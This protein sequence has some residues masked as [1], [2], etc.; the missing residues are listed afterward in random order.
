MTVIKI[1]EENK[2]IAIMR[3]AIAESA[4][5]D[6]VTLFE[7]DSAPHFS[8][9]EE[10]YFDPQ[11]HTF[12]TVEISE[13]VLKARAEAYAKMNQALKWFAD[14][15]WKV[16]KHILGEWADD[17]AELEKVVVNLELSYALMNEGATYYSLFFSAFEKAQA[18]A[19]RIL[20]EAPDHIKE[21]FIYHEAY[22]LSALD[23]LLDPTL[24]VE[25]EQFWS[26]DYVVTF[27]RAI[28]VNALIAF[29]DGIY[30]YYM[31]Y[32]M[33]AFMAT[34]YDLYW[35]YL[36]GEEYDKAVLMDVMTAFRGLH[37][38]AQVIFL[39][40]F[41]GED[42]L[43]YMAIEEF[44]N[45]T[46]ESDK[47]TSAVSALFEVEMQYVLFNYYYEYYYAYYESEQ[48]SKEELDAIVAQLLPDMKAAYEAFNTAYAALG[49]DEA[50]FLEDFGAMYEFYKTAL[51]ALIAEY[52]ALV[53]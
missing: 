50:L 23:K 53:A 36:W 51:D 49:T 40:Y 42:G 19:N 20:T 14:N 43:Y 7:V 37:P 6:N 13:E 22:S 25:D 44:L 48:I 34:A 35:N 52:G 29:S 16:N 46:Y 33:P 27:Y 17:F 26:Y 10:L 39:F 45:V 1:N 2:V 47:V 28:Y 31:A 8:N 5:A 24:V 41:E 15:D 38:D 4:K 3:G 21:Y 30:D 9:R 11:N 18:I 32:D 12:S